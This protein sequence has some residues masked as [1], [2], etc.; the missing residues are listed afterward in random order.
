MDIFQKKAG[1][2]REVSC[3]LSNCRAHCQREVSTGQYERAGER[4]RLGGGG[5]C[6]THLHNSGSPRFLLPPQ[7]SEHLVLLPQ[8]PPPPPSAPCYFTDFIKYSPQRPHST[9]FFFFFIFGY[10]DQGIGLLSLLAVAVLQSFL[11]SSYFTTPSPPLF[12][13]MCSLALSSHLKVS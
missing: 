2:W 8:H 9:H 3:R 4:K 12:S 11:F 10:C 1:H 7:S 13:F 6:K 5:G